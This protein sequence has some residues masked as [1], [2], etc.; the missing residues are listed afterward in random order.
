MIVCLALLIY[1]FIPKKPSIEKEIIH[2]VRLEGAVDAKII[3]IKFFQA[4]DSCIKSNQ[5]KSV[6]EKQN[7]CVQQNPHVASG[8]VKNFMMTDQSMIDPVLCSAQLPSSYQVSTGDD[9][10]DNKVKLVVVEMFGA[11]EQKISLEIAKIDNI[12]KVEKIVCPQSL[13]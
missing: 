10:K 8:S 9:K 11:Y 6:P 5:D 1:V 12:W 4:Y 2:T 13:R 3:A 7:A